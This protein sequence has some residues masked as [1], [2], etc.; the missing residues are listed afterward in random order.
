[1]LVF[2][3]DLSSTGR[4]TALSPISVSEADIYWNSVQDIREDLDVLI[5]QSHSFPSLKAHF[6]G[7][8]LNYERTYR[9][10]ESVP[11]LACLRLPGPSFRLLQGSEPSCGSI[12]FPLIT[13]P[14]HPDQVLAFL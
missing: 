4:I 13:P 1:M 8:E 10:T 9:N 5:E 12:F 2:P 14:F 6:P 3:S 7:V 11:S